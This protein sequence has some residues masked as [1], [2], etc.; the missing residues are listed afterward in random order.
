MFSPKS[1]HLPEVAGA[2]EF[3]TGLLVV[4][5]GLRNIQSFTVSLAQLPSA[6]EALVSGVLGDV[7]PGSDQKLTLHV[8]AVD[9][10]TPGIAPV[11]VNWTALGK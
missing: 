5:T 10:V 1:T 11:K 9:G 2:I 7:T 3:V 8:T 6:A 4:E